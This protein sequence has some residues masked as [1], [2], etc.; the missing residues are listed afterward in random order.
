MRP[1]NGVVRL[2][3]SDLAVLESGDARTDLNCGIEAVKPEPGYDAIL[4]AGYRVSI[5]FSELHSGERLAVLFRVT[6]EG[7]GSQHYFRQVVGTGIFADD[8]AGEGVFDGRFRIGPGRYHVN[9]LVRDAGGRVCSKAWSIQTSSPI[10]ESGETA[11][12]PGQV[13][14]AENAT[15]APQPPVEKGAGLPSIKI[16]LHLAPVVPGAAVLDA[17]DKEALVAM[18][19][20]FVKNPRVGRI[21]LVVFN[22]DQNRVLYR[23]PESAG[24][25]FPALGRAVEEAAFGMV[26]AAALQGAGL[27]DTLR[28]ELNTRSDAIVFI[29]PAASS[30]KSAGEF[31]RAFEGMSVPFFYW[32]YNPRPEIPVWGDV[33]DRTVSLLKGR[34]YSIQQPRDVLAAWPDFISRVR[35]RQ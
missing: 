12:R 4:Q 5:P 33:I 32:R 35:V 25:D 11:L 31:A 23:E 18:L 34:H 29:G 26:E 10:R 21:S 7:D 6:N 9:L 3:H 19:R 17:R 14:A 15:F 13:E 27:A 1:A 20:G 28:A 22:L 16:L 30:E 2:I 24:I 8:V